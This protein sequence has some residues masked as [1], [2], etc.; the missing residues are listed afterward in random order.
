MP[1]GS[2]LERSLPVESSTEAL[3]AWR[4]WA[5]TGRRDGS[6]L[7]LR[8][9]A[10]RARAWIPRR[11]AEASCGAGRFHDAP[12]PDCSCGLHGTHQVDLLRRTKNPAVLGRVAFW[13]RVVEHEM[14]FRARFGYP[15]R[16]RLICQ[17]CFWQRGPQEA[18]PSVVGWFSRD[19]LLPLCDEHADIAARYGMRPQ[20]WL[21]ANEVDQLLRSTYAVDLLAL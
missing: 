14:G 17:F 10:G 16:V 20:T 1:R 9:V 6:N 12:H 11:P 13:G 3:V 4:A 7:L 2:T 19:E 15:Q 18:V 21:S 8:P 5:L